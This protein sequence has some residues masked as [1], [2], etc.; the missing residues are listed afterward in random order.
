MT[1]RIEYLIPV[2]ND[3][4]P[5]VLLSGYLSAAILAVHHEY[6]FPQKTHYQ[7]YP[8]HQMD[9]ISLRIIKMIYL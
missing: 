2:F 6:R 7:Y 8:S 3:R 1:T 9:T 5:S 4:I